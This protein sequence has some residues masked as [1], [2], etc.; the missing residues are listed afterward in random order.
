[1]LTNTGGGAYWAGRAAARPLFAPNGQAMM[2][3]LPLF[4]LPKFKKNVDF[5][6]SCALLICSFLHIDRYTRKS[7]YKTKSYQYQIIQFMQF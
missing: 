4:A 1:M 6:S 3:A 5:T 7:S 2:F